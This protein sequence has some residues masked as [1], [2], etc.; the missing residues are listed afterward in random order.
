M[1]RALIST[2]YLSYLT[3]NWIHIS[4]HKKDV[5]LKIMF[6]HDRKSI[7]TLDD[8]LYCTL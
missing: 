2:S 3:K 6:N 1:L 7:K 5:R 8:A 4:F